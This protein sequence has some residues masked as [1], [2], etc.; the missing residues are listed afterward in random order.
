MSR[1]K[2]RVVA[3][4]IMLDG[5][6]PAWFTKINLDT[7]D[8]SNPQSCILGQWNG[9][10][11]EGKNEL[12][13]KADVNYATQKSRDYAFDADRNDSENT[14]KKLTRLWK[15]QIK[16]RLLSAAEAI[17]LLSTLGLSAATMLGSDL[18][19]AAAK[20]RRAK[21]TPVLGSV[22]TTCSPNTRI[23]FAGIHG[24]VELGVT[25]NDSV[26]AEYV[27]SRVYTSEAAPKKAKGQAAPQVHLGPT[28]ATV[29]INFDTKTFQERNY[30][31]IRPCADKSR[32][33]GPVCR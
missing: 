11:W 1:E 9:N 17:I 6:D 22:N 7:L 26:P 24:V 4:A 14:F 12:F 18:A 16:R 19:D 30:L 20:A 25:A 3:G 31:S 2:N 27:G 23:G 28:T 15:T 13:G 32:T 8:L 29:N 33:D 21:K 5:V 10:F